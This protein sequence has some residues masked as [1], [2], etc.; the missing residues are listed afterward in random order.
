MGSIPAVPIMAEINSPE[1]VRLLREII[2]SKLIGIEELP[3]NPKYFEPRFIFHTKDGKEITLECND[4]ETLYINES[5]EKLKR[6]PY[7]GS[8]HGPYNQ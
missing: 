8:K 5:D 7:Y 4:P 6:N 3:S 2:G 1:G